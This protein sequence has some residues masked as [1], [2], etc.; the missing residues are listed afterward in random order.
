[1]DIRTE[2]C[3]HVFEI[4]K[5]FKCINLISEHHRDGLYESNY[6]MIDLLLQNDRKKQVIIVGFIDGIIFNRTSRPDAYAYFMKYKKHLQHGCFK[7]YSIIYVLIRTICT[8]NLYDEYSIYDYLY[9]GGLY[10]IH[11]SDFYEFCKEKLYDS[12]S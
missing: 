3:R 4:A 10:T 8:T 2:Q 9:D 7:N 6:K 12:T 11:P 5:N 1:M